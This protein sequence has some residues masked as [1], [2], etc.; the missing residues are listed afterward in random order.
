MQEKSKILAE[1]NSPKATQNSFLSLF[2]QLSKKKFPQELSRMPLAMG[3]P[4]ES[5]TLQSNSFRFLKTDGKLIFR[6]FL[7]VMWWVAR[8]IIQWSNTQR[9]DPRN[10]SKLIFLQFRGNFFL[11]H[12]NFQ[13]YHLSTAHF[14]LLHGA[15]ECQMIFGL[16]GH[17]KGSL[18]QHPAQQLS[19]KLKRLTFFRLNSFPNQIWLPMVSEREARGHF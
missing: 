2:E 9:T 14:S 4:G 18:G 7:G 5:Q 12:Q 15:M 16:A 13:F 19:S 17:S 11:A 3:T 1:K 6:Q 10:C 8:G